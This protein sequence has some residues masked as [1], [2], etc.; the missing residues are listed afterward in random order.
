M[1]R[2]AISTPLLLVIATVFGVSSTLQAYILGRVE[3]PP[4]NMLG[5][6]LILNLVYWWVP[7][8]LAA[9]IVALAER[10]QP[11]RVSWPIVIAVHIGGALSYAVLHTTVML[12]TGA[13]VMPKPPKLGWWHAAQLEFLTQLDWMLMT[14]LFLVGLALAL[15][16][17]RESEARAVSAAQLET[18]L[19][20]AQL[21]ALQRQLHPHFLFNTL[22]TIAG[23]MRA[24]VDAADRMLDRLAELLR[25]TLHSSHAQEVTLRDE[26]ELLRKYVDIEQTRFGPRL[27]VRLQIAP[28]VLDARVPV[29][30]LQPLVE[31]AVRHGIAPH[32][33]PGLIVVDARRVEGQ[34]T[35]T[36]H[37]SG[38]GVAPDR[39]TLLNEG[40]GL[41]NTRARL[42]HL[43]RDQHRFRFANVDD[44]FCVTVSMPCIIDPH[45][46][47]EPIQM[48]AA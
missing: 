24:D 36:V 12:A 27:A 44:G 41:A 39:L 29:L 30:L 21:Q 9:P 10:V 31:N 25:A 33:R 13:V 28:D 42:Q 23:L 20:E 2:R 48:G 45:A 16:Y 32:T 43:Y 4:E 17:R 34:L 14:Y 11:G 38:E 37:D 18:R 47:A 26:L 1:A 5:H 19:V 7:A 22:N 8:L 3:G 35:V 6:L 15:V 40:V 46:A